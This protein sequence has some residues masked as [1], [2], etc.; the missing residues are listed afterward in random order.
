MPRACAVIVPVV[1][2]LALALALAPAASAW[3]VQR[4]NGEAS[5]CD[6]R[7]DQVVLPATHNSMSAQS[8]GFLLPNQPVGIPDQLAD[9]VRGFLVDTYA[10]VRRR[11]GVVVTGGAA[12]AERRAIYLCHVRCEIG[13]TPLLDVLRAM[14]RFLHRH[15]S[16]VLVIVNEDHVSADDFTKVVKRSG[17]ARYVYRGSAGPRWPT[18][19]R[20]IASRGQVVLL[21]ESDVRGAPWYHPA[22]EGIVQETPYSWPRVTQL[23]DPTM[24]AASCRPNRGGRRGSLFLVNHWS[25]PSV[26]TDATS[27]RVNATGALVRRAR[28]CRRLRGRQPTLLAVDRYRVGGL[29]TAARKLNA[30]RR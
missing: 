21:A 14:T 11:D 13:A 20:M 26:P 15:P 8:L 7:L 17:L 16:E 24:L 28:E 19:R 9:G 22:Y 27:R 23:T 4:C 5:L 12:S 1:A 29:F 25:P 30:Q 10:G 3:S 6:R 18:L 2:L